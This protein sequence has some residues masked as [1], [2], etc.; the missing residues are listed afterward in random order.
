[1]ASFMTENTLIFG[2]NSIDFMSYLGPKL[3]NYFPIFIRTASSVQTFKMLLKHIYFHQMI[4]LLVDHAYLV[5][6]II[7]F[8]ILFNI[9]CV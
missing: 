9:S 4:V 6:M 1:M 5:P 7:D 3:W 8:V 2:I